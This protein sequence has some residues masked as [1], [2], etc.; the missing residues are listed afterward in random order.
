MVTLYATFVAVSYSLLVFWKRSNML[1]L[2][3]MAF[4]VASVLLRLEVDSRTLKD[5]APYFSSFQIVKYD[6]IPVELWIEPYRL[7]L[8]QFVVL[9]GDFSDIRQI[10]AIYYLHFAIV[11]VFFLWLAWLKDV[12]FEIK[13]VLFLAFYPTIAFVWLRSGM[14]YVMAGYLLYTFSRG[15]LQ[16]LHY[17]LPAFHASSLAILVAKKTQDLKLVYRL[18][19]LLVL[20]ALIY[21]V[22][23][24]AY[25]RYILFKLE[26]YSDTIDHGKVQ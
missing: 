4:V 24:T 13:L 6:Y 15:R 20:S 25:G 2:L 14:A 3:S 11:T 19:A 5:F 21:A 9:F 26:H 17:I 18:A 22:L 1:V 10:T 16:A 23:E 12:T 8:F 7:L